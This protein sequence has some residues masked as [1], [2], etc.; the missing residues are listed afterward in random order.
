[1]PIIELQ[2]RE[3]IT[4]RIKPAVSSVLPHPHVFASL[5][6]AVRPAEVL[7]FGTQAIEWRL[8]MYFITISIYN[9]KKSS[10]FI[11]KDLAETAWHMILCRQARSQWGRTGLALGDYM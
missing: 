4:N 5:V 9:R 2:K 8:K 10:F 3:D 1:M 7:F 11:V 6:S